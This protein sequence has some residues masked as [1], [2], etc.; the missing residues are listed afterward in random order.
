V[1]ELSI[2]HG[3]QL[4]FIVGCPRSGTTWV[5]RLLAAHP[6]VRTGQESDLFDLY[7]GPQLRTWR[8]ELHAD[9]SGR[10][11]VGLACYL[12]DAEFTRTL[13]GYAIDLLKKMLGDLEPHQ[14]FV[15]K[16]PSHALYIPEIAELFPGARF[17]HVLRDAR[18]TVAS[19]LGASRSWGAGW[20]PRRARAAARMW[21]E[22]VKAARHAHVAPGK[23]CEVR[24]EDLHIS[25]PAVLGDVTRWLGLEWSAADIERAIQANRPDVAKAG[26]GTPI[27]LG[28]AFGGRFG[29]VVREP[30]GFVRKA[31]VGSWRS[32]LTAL[33]RLQVWREAR[34]LMAEVGYTWPRPWD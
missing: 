8:R 3:D 15:E 31:E 9:S 34:S 4:I 2:E 22:H 20:A 21:V 17:I 13:R 16:T 18:D 28:G 14:L 1:R 33:D 11:G 30:S 27:P 24:Y 6:N 5:Q 10:G 19:L 25:G 12:D 23:L 7:I 32:E 26:G 29:P